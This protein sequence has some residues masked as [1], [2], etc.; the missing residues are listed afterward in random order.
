[1]YIFFTDQH[2]PEHNILSNIH[3]PNT[4]KR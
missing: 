4:F 2:K 1:M 3:N